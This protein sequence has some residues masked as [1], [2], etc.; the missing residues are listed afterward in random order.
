MELKWSSLIS[1][2]LEEVSRINE[3]AGAYK[4]VY[5][6]PSKNNFYVYYVGQAENLKERFYQHLIEVEKNNCC[7]EYLREYHC[8][9]RATAVA[10]QSN[11]DGIEVTLYNK[12]KPECVEKIPDAEQIDINFT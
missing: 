7:I 2:K 10:K 12:Y 4:L 9:F 3:I 1:L 5:Q 6:D 8:F 11:R